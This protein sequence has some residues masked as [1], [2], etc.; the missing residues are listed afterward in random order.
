MSTMHRRSLLQLSGGSALLAH[1]LKGSIARAEGALP[2]KRI[3]VLHRPNGTIDEEWI[4]N[5]GPGSI[6]APFAGVW[7][8]AVAVRGVDVRPSNGSTGGSHEAGLVTIMTGANLGATYRTNDDYRS[9][10]ES[11]DQTLLKKAA[12]LKGTRIG[13]IQAGAHGDQDG[14]NEIPNTTLSYAGAAQPMYPVLKPQEIYQR[15][16][17]TLMPGGTSPESILALEKARRAKQ[18]VLDFIAWDLERARKQFPTGMK[19]DL[20]SHAAAIRELET[21]LDSSLNAAKNNVATCTPPGSVAGDPGGDYNNMAK[22]ADAHFRIILAAFRCDITRVVTFQWATGATRVPF[23]PLGTNNHHSTSHENNRGVLAK[24]DRW[25]SEK[26]AP[27]IQSLVDTPDLG[28]GKLIDNTLVWYV[29]EIAEGWNHSFNNYPFL[30]FGG[31]GVG[32]KSRGRVLDVSNKGHTSNDL[33]TAI[34]PV[35]GTTLGP[36]PTKTTSPVQ[37]LFA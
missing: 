33:W 22:I 21:Q 27:F 6:L 29:N 35:F 24:V 16:F 14:G 15:A 37:G 34:A 3:M 8:H 31:D 32:L 1:W 10:A 5:N 12:I 28:G 25:F 19:G 18:S 11:L 30:F 13:S 7:N 9:T 4:K 2:P 23:G 17:S 20:D 26:T 36:F